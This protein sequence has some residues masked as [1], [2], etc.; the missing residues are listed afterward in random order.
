MKE[1]LNIQQVRDK[2]VKLVFCIAV[3]ISSAL[4]FFYP[5]LTLAQAESEVAVVEIKV[6]KEL[7]KLYSL[8]ALPQIVSI[9]IIS[10]TR[11]VT[12]V[13]EQQ[14]IAVTDKRD[15]Y[16]V[17]VPSQGGF[18]GTIVDR[19][20]PKPM[21][22]QLSPKVQ[23][24]TSS[25]SKRKAMMVQGVTELKS[26]DLML[27]SHCGDETY[28]PELAPRVAKMVS[29]EPPQKS[30]WRELELVV[31]SSSE[32]S[33]T[34][35]EESITAQILSTI[36]AANIFFEP[37]ELK[38]TLTG[39]QIYRE[40]NDPFLAA[41]KSLDADEMLNVVKNEWRGKS[42]INRDVVAVFGTSNFKYTASSNSL[43]VYGLAYPS[44][45]C[46][47]QE[48]AVL[49]A[50]QG[51]IDS[52]GELSLS[53]T[54]A[55]ELGHTLGMSHT[56]DNQPTSLMS[57][58]FTYNPSGFSDSSVKDYLQFTGAGLSGGACLSSIPA[59][60][61]IAFEGGATETISIKE[62]EVFNRPIRITGTSATISPG[63]LVSGADFNQLTSEFTFQP[64]FKVANKRSKTTFMSQKLV[65]KLTDG[66]EI[67]KEL[68][69]RVTDVNRAPIIKN[70]RV[71]R[72]A[73]RVKVSFSVSDPDGDKLAISKSTLK[74]IGWLAGRKNLR[75][76]GTK[77]SFTWIP[78]SGYQGGALSYKIVDVEGLSTSVSL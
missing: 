2:A 78:E 11:E 13:R 36:A 8:S 5:A 75:F 59:P 39:V 22:Y 76:D 68:I 57:P 19:S 32:F 17:L 33:S 46:T 71:S 42:D 15:L 43:D 24:D 66:R 25:A 40:E 61:V 69:F 65:A 30:N 34:R 18:Y 10:N 73:A 38:I 67:T 50:T 41:L 45:V 4:F 3:F 56:L 51:S 48:Y 53:A 37:L 28:L 6:G 44:T 1:F 77:V 63:K 7:R 14:L 9:P 55:H 35:S 70:L 12:G 52:R 72:G 16:G 23:S 27:P 29:V 26:E 64:S 31:V 49:F 20:S 58:T 47:K 62:G 21:Y 54:L 60:V 74:S